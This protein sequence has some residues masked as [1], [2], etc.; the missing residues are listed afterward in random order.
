[1]AETR[2]RTRSFKEAAVKELKEYSKDH[3]CEY[4]N[5]NAKANSN[6]IISDN[7]FVSTSFKKGVANFF[8][9]RFAGNPCVRLTIDIS[10]IRNNNE[11]LKNFLFVDRYPEAVMSNE[12][13]VLLKPGMKLKVTKCEYT[14]SDEPFGKAVFD[15]YAEPIV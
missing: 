1:M 5:K 10:K 4:L 2:W 14:E 15:V 6:V 9:S 8:C 7:A 11:K 12:A 13:E 3:P